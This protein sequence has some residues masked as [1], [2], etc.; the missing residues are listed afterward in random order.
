M[1]LELTASFELYKGGRAENSRRRDQGSRLGIA[2]YSDIAGVGLCRRPVTT[3]NALAAPPKT[4]PAIVARLNA[5][6]NEVFRMPDIKAHLAALNMQ[7]VG[8]TPAEMADF[9][10][11]ETKRWGAVIRAANVTVN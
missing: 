4:P 2:E 9:L 8:G 6:I 5:A 11:S 7:P 10:K 3:W 1:F